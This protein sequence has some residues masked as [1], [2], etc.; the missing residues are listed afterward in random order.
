MSDMLVKMWKPRFITSPNELMGNSYMFLVRTYTKLAKILCEKEKEATEIE[1]ECS[2]S[3]E[4]IHNL[5][6]AYKDAV[7]RFLGFHGEFVFGE[8]ENSSEWMLIS[9]L[10][11]NLLTEPVLQRPFSG[12][13]FICVQTNIQDGKIEVVR[14]ASDQNLISAIIVQNSSIHLTQCEEDETYSIP[15]ET[16]A[17]NLICRFNDV[18][19]PSLPIHIMEEFLN[20]TI[21]DYKSTYPKLILARRLETALDELKGKKAP[22]P[23]IKDK[24]K[25]SFFKGHK[26]KEICDAFGID[27]SNNGTGVEVEVDVQAVHFKIYKAIIRWSWLYLYADPSTVATNSWDLAGQEQKTFC[28]EYG[29]F[30]VKMELPQKTQ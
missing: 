25:L 14:L 1:S 7:Q 16:L 11:G 8:K 28:K 2:L 10:G 3:T 23:V 27:T 5:S 24:L 12:K 22:K 20:P 29:A 26:T 17:I 15:G 13:D 21:T 30:E 6:I 18:T 19:P 9:I 4:E